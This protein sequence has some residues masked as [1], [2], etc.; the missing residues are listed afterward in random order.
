[1]ISWILGYFK[2]LIFHFVMLTLFVNRGRTTQLCPSTCAINTSTSS[3][4]VSL[5]Y[6]S[7]FIGTT[8]T[9]KQTGVRTPMRF[10]FFYCLFFKISYNLINFVKK[11]LLLKESYFLNVLVKNLRTNSVITAHAFFQIIQGSRDTG[12]FA[13]YQ[14]L[15]RI[16]THPRVLRLHTIRQ[17]S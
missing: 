11:H 3:K 9:L 14:S 2:A 17:V 1:M 16:W 7:N 13:D 12:L 15:M 6:K 10:V 4:F 8:S 5:L